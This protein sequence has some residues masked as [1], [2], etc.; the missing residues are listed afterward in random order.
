MYAPIAK[1]QAWPLRLCLVLTLVGCLGGLA[2]RHSGV[3]A[4]SPAIDSVDPSWQQQS[5]LKSANGAGQSFFGNDVAISGNTA[6]VGDFREGGFCRCGVYFR[7]QRSEV[8]AA[9]TPIAKRVRPNPGGLWFLS[10]HQR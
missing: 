8:V 10:G 4:L 9:T 3:E 6:I 1:A 5:Q 7:P 2:F